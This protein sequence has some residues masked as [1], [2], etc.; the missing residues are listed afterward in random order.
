MN[1]DL[2]LFNLINQFAGE[3]TYLDSVAIFFAKYF[4]YISVLFL[5]M[6]LI[7]NFN[8]YFVLVTSSLL[9][10]IVARF[11]IVDIIR[12]FFP[13]L[14]PFMENKVNLLFPY[15]QTAFPSGHAAFTFGLAT[16][17][18]CYNKKAGVLFFIAGFLISIS[19]VFAGIHWPSDII[20][21]A[22]VG[23]FSGW[24]INKISQ[25]LLKPKTPQ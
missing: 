20:T 13:R 14:R 24:L 15:I 12:Y 23:I 10:A 21:G 16:V 8:K 2:Y 11:V 18:Y 6:F 17:I 9:A 7:K 1:L 4:V 19:R 22:L 25:K 5:L 3:N